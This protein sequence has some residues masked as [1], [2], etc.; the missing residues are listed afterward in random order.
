MSVIPVEVGHV[1]KEDMVSL[2]PRGEVVGDGDVIRGGQLGDAVDPITSSNQ[3]GS[4]LTV[5]SP[6]VVGHVQVG[7]VEMEAGSK[8]G[9]FG[10]NAHL[11]N[12]F[13]DVEAHENGALSNNPI[14]CGRVG[15]EGVCLEE[16]RFLEV[17]DVVIGGPTIL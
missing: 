12:P 10:P 5:G 17:V 15:M 7:P 9:P 1:R 14:S 13:I 8:S 2:I 3:V 6:L 11:W 4:P 16:E